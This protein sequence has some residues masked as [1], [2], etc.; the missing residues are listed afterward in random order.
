MGNVEHSL[1]EKQKK[2]ILT[3]IDVMGV[4]LSSGLD[5][6]EDGEI[7]SAIIELQKMLDFGKE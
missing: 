2:A 3:A 7:D 4:V 5:S 6:G 1:N